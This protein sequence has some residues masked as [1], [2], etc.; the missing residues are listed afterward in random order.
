MAR[1]EW[2]EKILGIKLPARAEPA[3]DVVLH[4]FDCLLGK[5]Q[6]L[7]QRAAVEEQDFGT[8]KHCE[9][10]TLG[11]PFGQEPTCLHRQRHVALDGK[12]LAPNIRRVLEGGGGIAAN[13]MKQD[14]PV[15]SGILEQK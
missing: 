6:L 13:G 10:F 2:D 3:A 7:R 14:R 11:V 8:A 12:A 5:P 1:R 15:G 9:T 4:D